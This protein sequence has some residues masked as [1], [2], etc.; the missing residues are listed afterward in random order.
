MGAQSLSPESP[1]IDES[2]ITFRFQAEGRKLRSVALCQELR[3]PR[4]GPEL[5]PSAGNGWFLRSSRPPAARMEYLL[6]L[7]YEDGRE[8]TICDPANPLRAPGPFGDK[9]VIEFPGY[10]KPSWLEEEDG[11]RRRGQT[12]AITLE[13]RVL[14]SRVHATTW[15]VE[16]AGDGEPLPLLVVHDGPE[17]A[18]YSGLLSLLD[19]M[20]SRGRLPRMRC[21]LLAPIERNE[22]YSAS[23]PYARA[24]AEEYL[25]ALQAVLPAPNGR[26]ARIGMGAS[27]GG[28]AMMHAHRVHPA[29]FGALFLQSG[30]FFRPRLDDQESSF[31][32]FQRITRFTSTLDAGADWAHPV[33]ITMT[34]GTIEEN[35]HNNRRAKEDLARQ[36]YQVC[37]VENAD[38]HNWVS[39]RDTLEPHLIDLLNGMWA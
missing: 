13:S 8:E 39:W 2:H 36:G 15:A 31:P 18:R 22:M 28:L 1:E 27:L 33:P 19:H 7:V 32:R 17:Y 29:T 25:P 16:G 34:C 14:G 4:R 38:A 20:W 35:L 23:P 11:Q 5:R 3:R 21:A 9:S 26:N 37:L 30:S 6:H 24:L 10:R 12:S